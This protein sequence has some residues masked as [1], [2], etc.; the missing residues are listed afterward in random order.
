MEQITGEWIALSE[1]CLRL[2]C[3]L[4]PA[5]RKFLR[6]CVHMDDREDLS[7]PEG[8]L[9]PTQPQYLNRP[10]VGSGVPHVAPHDGYLQWGVCLNH[11]Q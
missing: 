5:W 11:A 4:G 1:G 6:Q 3:H 7:V 8:M 9:G 10:C 2:N